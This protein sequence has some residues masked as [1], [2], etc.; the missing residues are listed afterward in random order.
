LHPG[1]VPAVEELLFW[2]GAGHRVRPVR[3]GSL[4]GLPRGRHHEIKGG[5]KIPYLATHTG[6][7]G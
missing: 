5:E 2:G 4:Q 7:W 3:V 6:C 1:V